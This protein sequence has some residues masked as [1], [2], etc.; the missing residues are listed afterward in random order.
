MKE[1]VVRWVALGIGALAPVAAGQE[2]IGPYTVYAPVSASLVS[3]GGPGWDWLNVVN[4]STSIHDAFSGHSII[5]DG[6][7]N[8][9]AGTTVEMVFGS[10]V[11]N[12]AGDDLVMF[13]AR[14]SENDYAFSTDFDGF[15]AQLA[16]PYTAFGAVGS[17]AYYYGLGAG[18]QYRATI[19][20][21]PIDLSL[22]GVPAGASVTAVRFTAVSDQVDPLGVGAIVPAPA[23]AAVLA[24]LF[25]ARRRRSVA[26]NTMPDAPS[27]HA[28]RPAPARR[29]G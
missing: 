19:M 22:L 9:V 24:A 16:L 26:P 13:D 27:P 7:A 29:A 28:R 20:A 21:A 17:A 2:T 18:K 10:P 14:F 8:G 15:V 6:F 1:L 12:N 25:A 5:A 11:V 23:C 4:T 3:G